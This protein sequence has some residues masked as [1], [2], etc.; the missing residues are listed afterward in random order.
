[1]PLITQLQVT[2][3]TAVTGIYQHD[4]C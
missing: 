3:F 4:W 2:N 1:M